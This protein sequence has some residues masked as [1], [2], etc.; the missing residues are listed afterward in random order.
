MPRGVAAWRDLAH[1][2]YLSSPTP[3]SLLAGRRC[4]SARHLIAFCC[5][6]AVFDP[7]QCRRIPSA[8]R[9]VA[10]GCCS[11][12]AD[13]PRLGPC[14]HGAWGLPRELMP[15]LCNSRWLTMCGH[16]QGGSFGIGALSS[17]RKRCQS[18]LQTMVT[19][20]NQDSKRKYMVLG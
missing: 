4:N 9:S 19:D 2:T 18:V 7:C 1:R 14:H 11:I 16:W 15:S 20:L 8:R 13:I 12:H 10:T 5:A 6:L 3:C 17:A